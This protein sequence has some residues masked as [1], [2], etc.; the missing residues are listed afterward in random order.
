VSGFGAQVFPESPPK[1]DRN[2]QKTHSI[3]LVSLHELQHGKEKA[4]TVPSGYQ[5]PE[6]TANIAFISPRLT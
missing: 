4:V 3:D 1:C 5:V 6:P 2:T